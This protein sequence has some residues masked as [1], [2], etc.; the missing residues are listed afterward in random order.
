MEPQVAIGGHRRCQSIGSESHDEAVA[1]VAILSASDVAERRAL[2]SL[3]GESLGGG[4]EVDDLQ[5]GRFEVD[6]LI[7]ERLVVDAGDGQVS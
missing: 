5:G 1:V 4:G 3:E 6:P 2:D 7:A